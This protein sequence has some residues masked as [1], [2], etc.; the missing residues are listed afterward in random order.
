MALEY[1]EDF[2]LDLER[3][4]ERGIGLHAPDGLL[5]DGRSAERAAIPDDDVERD[6]LSPGDQRQ[7]ALDVDSAAVGLDLDQGRAE[8][9]VLTNEDLVIDGLVDVR[10]VV[11]GE[12]LHPARALD[13]A[14]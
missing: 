13:H 2:V 3:A 5:D 8:R 11:V 14:K 9:D 4:E 12:S 6:R 1:Y 7:V 10:D